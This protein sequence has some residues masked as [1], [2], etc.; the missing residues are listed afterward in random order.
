MNGIAI[1]GATNA[2]YEITTVNPGDYSVNATSSGSL[3]CLGS[4]SFTVVQSS[5]CSLQTNTF[6]ESN[7][8]MYPNP[9]K[10]QVTISLD[11][12]NEIIEKIS[13]V[14]ILGKQVIQLNKVNE[15]TKSIDLSS[16]NTGIYFIEIE[17][18]N[19]LVVKRKL[20]VN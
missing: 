4:T 7:I 2:T 3:G 13:V 10:N 12:T 14:D 18:Q 5:T 11:N 15:V 1:S 17:K 19:K 8:T 9:A 6:N 16:L 20:I